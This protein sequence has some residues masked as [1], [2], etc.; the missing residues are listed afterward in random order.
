M[1]FTEA[2]Q[3]LQEMIDTGT[4]QIENSDLR[5]YYGVGA[6]DADAV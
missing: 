3:A 6:P 5:A 2:E 1:R 4:S